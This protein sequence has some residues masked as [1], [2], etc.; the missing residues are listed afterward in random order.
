MYQQK[1]EF[2]YC[3]GNLFDLY[4][5][6]IPVKYQW[7]KTD[8]I[9]NLIYN[10]KTINLENSYFII[11]DRTKSIAESIEALQLIASPPRSNIGKLQDVIKCYESWRCNNN[12]HI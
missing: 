12:Y 8:N 10:S 1:D 3:E 4:E 11:T 2:Y 6:F 7:L 5:S 9:F